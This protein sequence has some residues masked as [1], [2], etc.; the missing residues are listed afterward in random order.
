MKKAKKKPGTLKT[1]PHPNVGKTVLIRDHRAGVLVGTLLSFDGP[2][3]CAAL[4][5]ARKIWFWKGAAA[6]EG[7][8]ARGLDHAGSK[9]GPSVV[10]VDCCDVV[11]MVLCTKEG[12]ASVLTAPEWKP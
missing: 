2:S 8:A 6:V 10:R 12:A 11:Q 9:V 5:D 1:A 7:I 3:K 4:S